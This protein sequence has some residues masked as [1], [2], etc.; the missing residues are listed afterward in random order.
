M[1]KKHRVCPPIL[2]YLLTCPIR[3]WK[4]DPY[5][6]LAPHVRPGMTALD[7]GCAMGFFTLPLAEMVGEGGRVIAVDIQEKMLRALRRRAEKAG[8][9]DRIV[10]VRSEADSPLPDTADSVD[11]ALAFAVLHETPDAGRVLRAL[12]RVLKSDRGGL[13]LAE[14][15]GHVSAPEF[16]KTLEAAQQ[17]GFELVVE[18][19]AIWHSH[20]AL[21]DKPE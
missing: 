21:L 13:L 7:F 8:L 11:F 19:L 18:R 14:P 2:G 3:R 4:Q 16:A 17:A 15:S 12:F 1:A 6:I 5:K 20:A 9:S 10:T